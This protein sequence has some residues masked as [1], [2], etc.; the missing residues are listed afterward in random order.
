MK[1]RKGNVQ[2]I[3]ESILINMNKNIEE[4]VEFGSLLKCK[5]IS[6]IVTY[7]YTKTGISW[8]WFLPLT[9][10]F[11][12]FM[13]HQVLHALVESVAARVQKMEYEKCKIKAKESQTKYK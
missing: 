2:T 11:K 12:M 6:D 9:L 13:N 3:Q 10:M 4:S 7:L 8:D 5:H 1:E